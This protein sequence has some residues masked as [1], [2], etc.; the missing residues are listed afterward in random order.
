MASVSRNQ[1]GSFRVELS[2]AEGR[3]LVRSAQ[4]AG[5]N[6]ASKF[7]QVLDAHLD[8][9]RAEYQRQDGGPMR[10]KYEALSPEKQDEVD[11]LLNGNE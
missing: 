8:A 2:A 5:V 1:D 6:P 7:Q 10:E 9:R 3:V 11:A 4:E